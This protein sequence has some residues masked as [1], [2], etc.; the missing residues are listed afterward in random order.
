MKDGMIDVSPDLFLQAIQFPEGHTVK[1]IWWDPDMR[2]MRLHLQGPS[3]PENNPNTSII[4]LLEAWAERNPN[5][6]QP[7]KIT[8]HFK[9]L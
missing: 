7:D 1:G 9:Q 6:N 2:V 4:P 5:S 3:M 8:W